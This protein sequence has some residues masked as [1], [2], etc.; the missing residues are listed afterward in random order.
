[1]EDLYNF[2]TYIFTI[3][4]GIFSISGRKY[5]R[6]GV[7]RINRM[8]ENL[9]RKYRM[10]STIGFE[11]GSLLM[12]AIFIL[13]GLYMIITNIK[14]SNIINYLRGLFSWAK[15]NCGKWKLLR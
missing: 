8:H 11:R 15:T 2:I 12:G 1:M 4:L 13:A 5:A 6:E 14:F 7:D 9:G 10:Y 3:F